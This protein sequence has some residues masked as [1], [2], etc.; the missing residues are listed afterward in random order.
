[1]PCTGGGPSHEQVLDERRV[2]AALCAILRAFAGNG[3][4]ESVLDA[5]DY[6]NAG[7]TRAWIVAWWEDHQRADRNR[8]AREQEAIERNE[9][10]RSARAKLSSAERQA[11]GLG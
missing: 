7:I 10:A 9:L 3:S 5:I 1:M 4:L 11:L 8:I 2:T 6:E